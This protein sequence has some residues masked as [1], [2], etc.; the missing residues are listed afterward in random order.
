MDRPYIICHMMISLDGKV[1]GEF[2]QDQAC[3]Q[4]TEV[5][6]QRNRCYKADAY[7]CGRITMEGSFTQG[8]Y[9]DLTAFAPAQGFRWKMDYIPDDM[10]GLC[11]VAFDPHGRLGWQSNR[12]QDPDTDPGYDKARIIE[13]VTEQVDPR[14]LG[15]LE[16]KNICYLFAGEQQIDLELALMKL[17]RYFGIQTLLLEGGSI[18][19]GA[20]QRAGLV[21]ELSLVVAPVVGDAEGKPLFL[22]S[23]M[24]EYHLLQ[25]QNEGG[26]V[27]MNYKKNH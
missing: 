12:V 3:R 9:P 22:D 1:T 20:F 23:R 21:D 7:A 16:S 13:V 4:A 14:Y 15:Y 6:Y 24:E 5:Y 19:N 26:A 8:W 18:L 2:L 11:A 27:W 25:V 17:R 10:D